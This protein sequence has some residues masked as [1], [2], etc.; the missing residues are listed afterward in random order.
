MK[1]MADLYH[2]RVLELAA[3]IPN[4]GTL[5]DAHGSATRLARICG[6]TVRVD[7]KLAEDN[8]TVEAIAVEPKACALGQ[9]ATAILSEH[10]VG[11]TYDELVEAR[12]GMRAMLKDGA[13]PP[14]GRF[15]ELRHLEGVRDYPPRH[16]STMLAFEAV[17]EA[18]E[19]ART[20][21]AA[22]A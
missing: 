4:V 12:D 15:W 5:A 17:L 22:A 19:T 13:E 2:N 8:K 9:A 1:A 18:I 14:R 21:R 11:A 10:A 7:I 20:A 3:D 6:S 16:A